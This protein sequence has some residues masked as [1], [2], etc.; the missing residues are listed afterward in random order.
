MTTSEDSDSATAAPALDFAVERE[1]CNGCVAC[2]NVFPAIFR[3]EGDKAVI[4]ATSLP[5]SA[6]PSR[7]LNVCPAGA[8]HRTAAAGPAAAALEVVPGWETAWERHRRDPEDPLERERR[9]G[10]IHDVRRI[11]GCHVLRIELPRSMPRHELLDMYG[12]P[13]GP[14]EYDCT[15]QPVGPATI[16]VRARLVDPRLVPLCGKLNSFPLGFKVDYRF[17]EPIAAA[18]HRMDLHD[19]WV[20]AFP[21]GAGDPHA[22]LG[23]VVREHL[24]TL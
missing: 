1:R 5:A 19:L 16:S 7:I 11:A 20:Y 2:V 10:R 12:I 21:E 18:F 8:I 4:D 3:L 22:R 15:L 13:L 6:L 9:Y 17:P 23:E 14:P 24:S